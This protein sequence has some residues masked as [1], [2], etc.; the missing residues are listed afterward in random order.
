MFCIG[1]GV[2]WHTAVVEKC[3]CLVATFINMIIGF[4]LNTH[5]PVRQQ[6]YQH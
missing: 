2:C 5:F 4:V 3:V 6:P 1:S